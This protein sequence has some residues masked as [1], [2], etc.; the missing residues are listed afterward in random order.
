MSSNANFDLESETWKVINKHFD[1]DSVLVRH[2]LASFNYFLNTEVQNIVRERDYQVTINSDWNHDLKKYTKQYHVW[3]DKVY[4]S[5]PVIYETNGNKMQMYPNDARLRNLTYDSSLMIDI[6]HKLVEVDPKTSEENVTEY[7]MLSKFDCGKIPIMLKSDFCV[8]SEQSNFTSMEMGE[9]EYDEGGYFVVKGGEK[10]IV[11]QERKC[12]NKVYGFK[13]KSSQ[14]KY[15][16]EVEISSVNP[17]SPAF[18]INSVVKL[19]AR[20][21]EYGKAIRVNVKSVKV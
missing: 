7:P 20:E 3:F 4:I 19:T 21:L 10:V 9:G 16:H 17:E 14:T 13:Q 8:L 1:Q 6:H 11:C 15:S 5:K 2:H 18:V 12:E